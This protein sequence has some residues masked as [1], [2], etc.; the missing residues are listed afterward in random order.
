MLPLTIYLSGN[1]SPD[2]ATHMWRKVY[3]YGIINAVARKFKMKRAQVRKQVIILDPCKNAFNKHLLT[4][5]NLA[6]RDAY[7]QYRSSSQ[8]L[9]P[10]KDFRMMQRSD[11]VICNLELADPLKPPIGT[12][13][14]LAW[15]K[16]VL[17]N[18][19]VIAIVGIR[20]SIWS[21]HPFQKACIDYEVV[22]VTDAIKAT[23]EYF[24]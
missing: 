10:S 18:L 19:P 3:T 17:G 24:L 22:S 8:R 15:C 23:M 4:L 7:M 21:T 6:D 2:P 12:T 13:H 5:A 1:I 11:L 14:E 20:P 9:L 16:G